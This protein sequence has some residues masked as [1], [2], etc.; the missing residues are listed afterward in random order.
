MRMF[1]FCRHEFIKA[2]I[3]L[4]LMHVCSLVIFGNWARE[5]TLLW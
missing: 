4:C 3:S 2:S 1:S 5:G